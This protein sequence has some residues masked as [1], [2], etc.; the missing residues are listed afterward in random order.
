[1]YIISGVDGDLFDSVTS[2][3]MGL[4]EY[5]V[6]IIFDQIAHAISVSIIDNCPTQI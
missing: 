2:H 3:E 1:M 4:K 6:K 5:E